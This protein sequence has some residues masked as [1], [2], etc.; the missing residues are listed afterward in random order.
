[1]QRVKVDSSAVASIGYDAGAGELDV[2][3]HTG[4]VYRY[5]DVPRGK[6]EALMAAE[7]IGEYFN[8]HIRQ[9]RYIEIT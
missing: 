8:H 7:S 6:F 1:M 9:H 3:F 4:R 5:F 2:E